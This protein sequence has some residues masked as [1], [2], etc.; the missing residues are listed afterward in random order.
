ML[1]MAHIDLYPFSSTDASVNADADVDA[2]CGQ[3]LKR[4]SLMNR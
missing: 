2:Q 1:G 3:D 4:I